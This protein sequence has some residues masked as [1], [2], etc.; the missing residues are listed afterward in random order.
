MTQKTLTTPKVFIDQVRGLDLAK[1]VNKAIAPGVYR[2]RN[3]SIASEAEYLFG[4]YVKALLPEPRFTVWVDP[5]LSCSLK[6][7]EKKTGRTFQPDI[8]VVEEEK[9]IAAFETMTPG[10]RSM[11]KTLSGLKN[12]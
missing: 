10:I 9:I 12:S 1:K 6:D 5:S 7:G 4:R 11:K 3:S 2:G 8:C